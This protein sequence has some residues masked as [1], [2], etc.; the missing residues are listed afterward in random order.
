[1]PVKMSESEFHVIFTSHE[2]VFLLVFQPL[3]NVKTIL[4]LWW[5]RNERWVGS[6]LEQTP[7][8]LRPEDKAS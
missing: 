2:M 5:Y 7:S 4:S 6:G 3:K 8:S 1:M